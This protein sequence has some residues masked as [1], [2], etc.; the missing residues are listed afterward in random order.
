MLRYKRLGI[1]AML[2]NYRN[3]QVERK[4]ARMVTDWRA[5]YVTGG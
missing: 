2:R 5:C 4:T 1:P 3:K